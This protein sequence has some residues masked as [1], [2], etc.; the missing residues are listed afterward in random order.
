MEGGGGNKRAKKV[1][2]DK[3]FCLSHSVSPC[4]FATPV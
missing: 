1:Q 2:N 3:K 4:D